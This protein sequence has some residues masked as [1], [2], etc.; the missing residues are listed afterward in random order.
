MG[1][2]DPSEGNYLDQN[3]SLSAFIRPMLPQAMFKCINGVHL[4]AAQCHMHLE[5]FPFFIPPLLPPH[6]PSTNKF[7]FF[8]GMLLNST[9]IWSTLICYQVKT[10]QNTTCI[11]SQ[12]T[13]VSSLTKHRHWT[14]WS[15]SLSHFLTQDLKKKPDVNNFSIHDPH[16]YFPINAFFFSFQKLGDK[17]KR[18]VWKRRQPT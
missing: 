17:N 5:I 6:K 9:G 3:A 7:F 4:Q 1:W 13:N 16:S 14:D 8:P 11:R 2:W 12:K 18:I 15:T 10:P